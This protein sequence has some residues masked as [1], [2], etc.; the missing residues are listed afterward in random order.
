MAADGL[1][2]FAASLPSREAPNMEVWVSPLWHRAS[3]F[4]IAILCLVTEWAIRR[5][6][7]MA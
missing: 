6:F 4:L 2:A 1:T 3:Y 5:R 7:G